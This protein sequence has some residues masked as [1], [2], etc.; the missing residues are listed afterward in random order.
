ML[1]NEARDLLIISMAESIAVLL[2]THEAHQDDPAL[3]WELNQQWDAMIEAQ[4]A[5][6][7]TP[8]QQ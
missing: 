5:F 2:R 6:E 7:T 4:R 1:K 3:S 8:E